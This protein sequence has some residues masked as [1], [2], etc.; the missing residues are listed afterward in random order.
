MTQ[1]I[2]LGGVEAGGTKFICGVAD[3]GGRI[4]DQI[5]IPTTTPDET[6]DAVA[7][8]FVE[9]QARHGT[10]A[11]LAIGSFGP[12]SLRSDAADYGT[13]TTTPKPGWSNVNLL[14]HLRRTLDVRMTLDTDV[15]GS[16]IGEGLFGSGKGLETFCYV[17]V[18]TGIGVG[19]MIGGAPHG[20]ANHP[21]AGHI[22]MPR[23]KGDETFSGVCPFHGDCLEGLAS[24]P[25]LQARWGAAAETFYHDHPAWPMAAEYIAGLCTNLTYTLRPERIII[26]GGVMQP[27]MYDLVRQALVRQLGGYD[28]SLRGLDMKTYIAAPTAGVS[29]GLI[30]AW[31]LAYRSVTGTWPKGWAT[32]GHDQIEVEMVDA[33]GIEPV[34]PSV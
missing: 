20:G 2:L 18:G 25:A 19:V 6:L 26:G 8:F 13:I 33:T 15:N 5:R 11:A 10:L 1:P 29:A 27:H 7:A 24:G 14:A 16:A 32:Q 30:G 31:A 28:A 21:E 23:A 22:R 9:A 17:T 3:V 12:L 4:I 34:T